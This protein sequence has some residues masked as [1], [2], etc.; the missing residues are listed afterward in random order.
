MSISRRFPNSLKLTQE[1]KNRIAAEAK[2]ELG[3]PS[4]PSLRFER[5]DLHPD[6]K[7]I[8]EKIG[9]SQ[10]EFAT[11]F[12][13]SVKTVQHWEQKRTTPDRPALVLLKTIEIAP[14]IVEA[15]VFSLSNS[16]S[17]TLKLRLPKSILLDTLLL[18]S[19]RD[20]AI[21]SPNDRHRFAA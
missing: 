13:L 8:R 9:L 10:R 7:E 17:I 5:V 21:T 3:M 2:R 16:V 12:G 4:S 20:Q 6:A 19:P 1:E 15:A 14:E 18:L 11:R